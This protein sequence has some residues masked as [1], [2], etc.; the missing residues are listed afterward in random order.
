VA[1]FSE[2][3]WDDWNEEHIARHSVRRDEVAEAIDNAPTFTRSH[4][5]TYQL[6]GQT[7]AGRFLFIVL[8]PRSS[9]VYD[10]VTAR[11]AT[12]GERR[13]ARRR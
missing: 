3:I 6:V 7:D 11:D 2:L 4:D 9:G 8:A 1:Y 13:G 10:P 12:Q 5:D